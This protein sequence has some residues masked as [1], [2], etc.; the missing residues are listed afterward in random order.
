MN[1]LNVA[2]RA[3]IQQFHYGFCKHPLK[4]CCEW[5]TPYHVTQFPLVETVLT[6]FETNDKKWAQMVFI[7]ELTLEG[8][9]RYVANHYSL[10]LISTGPL[11][12]GLV[13]LPTR[14]S[15]THGWRQQN[16][17]IFGDGWTGVPYRMA[18]WT[19]MAMGMVGNPM[20]EVSICH[21][22]MVSV[23]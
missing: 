12:F 21:V 16:P 4:M 14:R 13:C 22:C 18:S 11:M 23:S 8:W 5:E 6:R 3:Y 7:T 17:S 10:G 19:G 1:N 2:F 20:R 15:L 9:I